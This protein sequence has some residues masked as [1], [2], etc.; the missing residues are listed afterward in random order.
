MCVRPSVRDIML[1]MAPNE[2][3]KRGLNVKK[4]HLGGGLKEA[5]K[6]NY[7]RGGTEHKEEPCPVGACF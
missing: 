4:Q 1:K 3:L 5:F 2:F 7:F 6:G